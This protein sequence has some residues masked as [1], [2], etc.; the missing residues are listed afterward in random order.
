MKFESVIDNIKN[1]IATDVDS[2]VE[3]VEKS[4]LTELIY[5]QGEYQHQ[6]GQRKIKKRLRW[7]YS[8]SNRFPF[9]YALFSFSRQIAI[10]IISSFYDFISFINYKFLKGEHRDIAFS[11][12]INGLILLTAIVLFVV[13]VLLMIYF[14]IRSVLFFNVDSSINANGCVTIKQPC[15]IEHNIFLYNTAIKW[16]NTGI[17]LAQGDNVIITSSGS[18]Y[19]SIRD[20]DSAARVNNMIRY[21]QHNPIMEESDNPDDKLAAKFAIYRKR[22]RQFG[23]LLLQIQP[24]GVECFDSISDERNNSI[25][26]AVSKDKTPRFDLTTERS[27]ILYVSIND[28]FLS[29]TVVKSINQS[30]TDDKKNITFMYDSLNYDTIHKHKLENM[31]FDDN[32]GEV[33]LNIIVE[34]NNINIDN[35]TPSIFVRAYRF[36]EN[37]DI[38][39]LLLFIFLISCF[40]LLDNRIGKSNIRRK[41]QK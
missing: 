35:I 10:C 29:D 41:K 13:S 14:F 34:R 27:G 25:I 30:S 22:D 16:A 7:N 24:S 12:R 26:Q 2:S 32:V 15:G 21:S 3:I 18:Y 17:E 4:Y 37:I 19:G 9:T 5:N 6:I 39:K 31:W 38:K 33:L 23:S 8:K 28:I 20:I 36:I 1:S 11:P 40:L